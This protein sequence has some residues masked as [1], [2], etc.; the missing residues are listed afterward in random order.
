MNVLSDLL[1]FIESAMLFSITLFCAFFYVRSRDKFIGRTLGV[2]LPIAILFLNK[3][4]YSY[5]FK[6]V[7]MY[8]IKYK[9]TNL[10]ELLAYF[11]AII[12]IFIMV[13]AVIASSIYILTLFPISNKRRTQG[14][15]FYVSQAILFLLVSFF[16]VTIININKLVTTLTTVICVFFP[17]SSLLLFGQAIAVLLYIKKIEDTKKVQLARNFLIA[18]LPQLIY[19][20][21]DLIIKRNF[22]SQFTCFSYTIFSILSFYHIS[23]YYFKGYE[24]NE[25][26][27]I[28]EKDVLDSFAFTDREMDVL[29]LIMIGETNLKISENLHISVNTVKTHV[30]NI[31][32]KIDVSNRVQLIHKIRE[33]NSL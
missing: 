11:N 28:S 31:Y 12:N 19:T 33:T 5:A 30:K 22:Q 20:I 24:P 17:L 2:L 14:L 3:N 27:K 18:F 26:S 16:S 1:N 8:G 13:I 23:S 29:K 32:K 21:L 25:N 4:I 10:L 9:T 15:I 7:Q 6:Y